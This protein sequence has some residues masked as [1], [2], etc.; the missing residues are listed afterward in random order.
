[1][2]YIFE[3]EGFGCLTQGTR[4][5]FT[6]LDGSLLCSHCIEEEEF[7][8]KR[9]VLYNLNLM[10]KLKSY[11]DVGIIILSLKNTPLQTYQFTSWFLANKFLKYNFY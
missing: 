1:M 8:T 5:E 4:K 7:E 2:D 9:M 3:C 6:Q 10:G 11:S